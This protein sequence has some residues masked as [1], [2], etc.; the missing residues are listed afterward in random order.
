MSVA[1]L[2]QAHAQFVLQ[3]RDLVAHRA[4]GHVQGFARR[5]ETH[6]LGNGTEDVE[7]VKGSKSHGSV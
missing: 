2:E 3:L 1:A 4:L 7:T 6:F 5:R